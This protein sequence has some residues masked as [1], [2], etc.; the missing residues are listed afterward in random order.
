VHQRKRFRYQSISRPPPPLLFY[1]PPYYS[2]GILFCPTI[3][4][5]PRTWRVC[6]NQQVPQPPQLTYKQGH[7]R[8]SC[9]F[10]GIYTVGQEGNEVN[11]Y[12]AMPTIRLGWLDLLINQPQS[13][14]ITIQGLNVRFQTAREQ[15]CS[16]MRPALPN[17]RGS[18]ACRSPKRS[19]RL[20]ADRH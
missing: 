6:M 1:G 12:V 18:A 5:G 11:E 10:S 19:L 17:I 20:V 4:K 3:L 2:N 16:C 8:H 13:V 7:L 9:F 14:T 15:G